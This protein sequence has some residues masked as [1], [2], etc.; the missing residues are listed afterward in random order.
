MTLAPG[1]SELCP[2]LRRSSSEHVEDD[3]EDMSLPQHLP[4]I[5]EEPRL[6]A[7]GAEASGLLSCRLKVNTCEGRVGEGGAAFGRLAELATR[8]GAAAVTTAPQ[9][10]LQSSPSSLPRRSF[11]PAE[12]CEPPYSR[13]WLRTHRAHCGGSP[14]RPTAFAT[15]V[16]PTHPQPASSPAAA[17][18]AHGAT[19]PLPMD[20]TTPDSVYA[21]L[22]S[23]EKRQKT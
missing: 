5:A 20:D 9:E 13:E 11:V 22:A 17:S 14:L 2:A 15:R 6:P 23:L 19:K 21:L 12:L 8:R 10:D 1:T 3:E 7:S 18:A 4:A 16:V